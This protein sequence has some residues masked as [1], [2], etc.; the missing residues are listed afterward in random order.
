MTSPDGRYQRYADTWEDPETA[1]SI[2]RGWRALH[3][4]FME[5]WNYTTG[6]GWVTRQVRSAGPPQPPPT[7]RRRGR[8]R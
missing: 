1:G 8:R 4:E 3:H 6:H 2:E 5:N 7:G